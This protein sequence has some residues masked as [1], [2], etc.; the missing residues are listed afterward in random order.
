M[1]ILILDEQFKATTMVDN[2]E[3]LIWTERYN[4]CG[5]FE[6]VVPGKR[7][8][9]KLIKQNYY[10]W[11]R[12]SDHDM[13]IEELKIQNGMFTFSGRS[14]ESMLD[15]RIIWNQTILNSKLQ[16]AVKRL[17]QE[18]VIS[19]SISARKIPGFIFEE[20]T[21]PA[22]TGLEIRVQY[23]GDNLYEVI[24]A[25]CE[26]FGIGFSLRLNDKNQ[27]V[28][29][30][31]SGKDRTDAQNVNPHVIFSPSFDNLINSNYIE[32]EKALK[33]VTLVAG[34]D[35][36]KERRTKIVGSASGISRRELYTDARDIQSETDDGQMSDEE[37][38]AQLEQ[39]GKEKLAECE[40]TKMFEGE[41]E[42]N[43]NFT[44]GVDYFKG[45]IVQIANE[46]GIEGRA[47]VSEYIMSQD[48]SGYKAYP[49]FT[50]I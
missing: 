5:D 35:S 21:D 43:T 30:L 41:A 40:L 15:R 22:I 16:Y 10:A 28:F 29:K 12:D 46:Y 31:Y 38:M 13:I 44:Y 19:P 11:N 39:R 17:L 14:L 50:M 36:G 34:E 45:D 27:F 6:M 20:S 1:N 8:T 32:S 48:S 25:I 24:V 3:S 2:F 47:R 9:L 49:S 37:Y 4:Q 23:T 33:N 26:S 18:N 42:P 7:E